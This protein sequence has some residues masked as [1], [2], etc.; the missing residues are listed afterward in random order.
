M[1]I[2]LAIAILT[3]MLSP[4]DTASERRNALLR[5][6]ALGGG[7][8]LV[9][10]NT[11][12]GRDISNEFDGAVGLAPSPTSDITDAAVKPTA[13]VSGV[14][15]T[16]AGL[17][18]SLSSWGKAGV[19]FVAGTAASG[20]LSSWLPLILIGGAFLVLSR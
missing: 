14:T 5:A 1:W 9:A 2:S 4:R 15:G 12:W 7:S 3:Y 17:W 16:G 10:T 20:A 8:Y 19:G 11:D 6:A 13:A 18:S